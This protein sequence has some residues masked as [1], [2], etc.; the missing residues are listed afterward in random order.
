MAAWKLDPVHSSVHFAARHMMVTNVR[1]QFREFSAEVSFDPE[2]PDQ[3]R[4]EATIQATSIDTGIEQR[5]AHLRSADFL[6][7]EHYP[8]LTFRSTSIEPKGGDR[9]DVRGD[10]AIRGETH[11]VTLD[12]EFLGVA[13]NLQGGRSAGFSAR[14]RISR[15]EWG[16]TW[17]VGLE[18]G[19]WLVGDEVRIDIDLELLSAATEQPA[20]SAEKGAA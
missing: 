12:V 3:G 1:G 13:Q 11:P 15:K 2:H 10:L 9:Y 20:S 14:T 6:D 4:V 19:G 16:L 8:T 17:N 18:T 7:V 5:D